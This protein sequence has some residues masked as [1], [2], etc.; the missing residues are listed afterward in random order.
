[1]KILILSY[2]YTPKISPR[3]FR[4]TSIAEYWVKQGNDVDV[5]CSWSPSL[6][7]NEVLNGVH[8]YRVGGSISEVLRSWLKKTETHLNQE[9]ENRT[10]L[11]GLTI[12]RVLLCF[13]KWIHDHSW[14]IIYWPDYACLWYFPA[15]RRARALHRQQHYDAMVTASLPFTAHLVGLRLKREHP[16]L[17]WLAD[18]GDPF[19]FLDATPVNNR[20]LFQHLDFV[21]ERVVFS[22]ANALTV[23]TEAT[24]NQ[25]VSLFPKSAPKLFVIPPLLLIEG[26][27]TSSKVSLFP[28]DGKIRLVYVGTLYKEIRNPSPLLKLFSELRYTHLGNR[29]EFHFFGNVH[30]CVACF[31]LYREELGESLFV[32]GVVPHEVAM[33]AMKEA[34]ILVNIGNK[35]PYQ[36]PSKVVEYIAAEKPVLNVAQRKDDSSATFFSQYYPWC[37]CITANND[38]SWWHED[39]ETVAY[40]LE[41]PPKT[42]PSQTEKY[43]SCFRVASIAAQYLDLLLKCDSGMEPPVVLRVGSK[44]GIVPMEVACDEKSLRDEI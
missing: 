3:A 24:R 31:E 19:S 8:V 41:S 23:T 6:H 33:Q 35:T 40:F 34:D 18:S 7:R 44:L 32:H 13:A 5:I 36:L 29:L 25:Y 28:T 1:M 16:E 17:P 15:V 11:T 39:I 12:K 30:D 10:R 4:W 9:P 14:K 43:K 42:E 37:L 27:N 20:K 2:S 22:Q 38:G 21:V 26:K